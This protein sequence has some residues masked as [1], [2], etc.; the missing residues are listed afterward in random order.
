MSSLGPLPSISDTSLPPSV[1]RE[2]WES[3]FKSA[4]VGKPFEFPDTGTDLLAELNAKLS[5]EDA[6]SEEQSA[7]V[8]PMTGEVAENIGEMDERETAPSNAHTS[9]CDNPV[10][11][12]ATQG[13]PERRVTTGVRLAPLSKAM[14]AKS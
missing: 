3:S 14:A 12:D 8:L 4:L 7:T 10:K 11:I 6:P 9:G 13:L 2:E 5:A 1:S